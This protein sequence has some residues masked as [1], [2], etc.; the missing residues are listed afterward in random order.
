MSLGAAIGFHL[1]MV[2]HSPRCRL[3]L[4]M[5][6]AGLA[7]VYFE[8]LLRFWGWD[9]AAVPSAATAWM[10]NYES[11]YTYLWVYLVAFVLPT[12][13]CLLGGDIV[14]SDIRRGRYPSIVGR[15]GRSTYLASA[16]AASFICA[17]IYVL[18]VMVV[19]QLMELLAFPAADSIDRFQ[20][21]I[22]ASAAGPR[23]YSDFSGT[24]PFGAL[25]GLSPYAANL[26]YMVYDSW[27][28][29][30]LVALACALSLFFRKSSLAIL[31]APMVF[32]V[33]MGQIA[34]ARLNPLVNLVE[35][36]SR[37]QSLSLQDAL[38][39]PALISAAA[40]LLLLVALHLVRGDTL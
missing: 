36:T 18:A 19:S 17:F 30:A 10:G 8:E 40:L 37:A 27:Y 7:V 22:Y 25:A 1:R 15:M 21:S 6:V 5:G 13:A 20:T 14:L 35:S 34:P 24:L 26:A 32:I 38:L 33:A 28:I 39:V 31:A 3:A 2:R 11:M 4:L 23:T 9:R 29:A 16:V 12:L